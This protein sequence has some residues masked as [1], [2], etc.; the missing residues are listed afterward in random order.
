M[1]TET[2]PHVHHIRQAVM[3]TLSLYAHANDDVTD[4]SMVGALAACLCDALII[5]G[6]ELDDD[7]IDVIRKTYDVCA[8][9]HA[10]KEKEG[11]TVQ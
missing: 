7:T 1:T 6:A 5:R 4:A 8:L 3:M 11:E 2:K 9:Q 10:M